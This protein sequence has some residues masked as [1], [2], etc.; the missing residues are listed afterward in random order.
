VPSSAISPAISGARQFDHRADQIIQRLALVGKDLGRHAIDQRAQD[1][2]FLLRRHQR[3]HHFGHDR[4]ARLERDFDRRLEN[5]LGLHFIDFG[6]RDPQAAAAMA[7]HGVEFV[8]FPGATLEV[9]DA[10]AG[11]FGEFLELGIAMRQ[12]FVQRRIEQADGD[13]QARH[14]VEDRD[15]IGALFGQQLGQRGAAA[16]FVFGQ[17]HLAHGGNAPGLEEHVLGAAQADAFGAELAGDLAIERG[18]GVGAH[19]HAAVLVGPDHQRGEI[20]DQFG[21][22]HRHFAGHDLAGRTVERDQVAF[23]HFAVADARLARGHV[24]RQA[25]GARNAGRPMP[26]ATTAAWLVIRRAR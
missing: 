2:E 20:A 17:D 7:E 12:E 15:E 16:G 6:E 21:F 23:G 3:D 9:V 14:H 18:F 13:R 22:H 24:D 11:H 25:R 10:K 5:G 8:Q 1:L 26:R 4:L 19:F